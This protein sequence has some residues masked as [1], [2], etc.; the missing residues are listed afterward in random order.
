MNTF[1][2][3]IRLLSYIFLPIGT[4]FLVCIVSPV[5]GLLIE[6]ENSKWDYK[7]LI[8]YSKILFQY[9]FFLIAIPSAI[10]LFVKK[11]P[12][13]FTATSPQFPKTNKGGFGEKVA[14][15]VSLIF[16]GIVLS[17]FLFA[18]A[19]GGFALFN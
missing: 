8:G 7:Y 5:I 12:S 18:F 14:I 15:I 4:I 13:S 19:I 9:G 10:I 6:W 11:T 2:G 17:L 1:K 16:F 3:V